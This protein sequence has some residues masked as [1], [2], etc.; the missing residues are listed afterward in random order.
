MLSLW[1]LENTHNGDHEI[2]VCNVEKFRDSQT[3]P[4]TGES[5]TLVPHMSID[6]FIK[7]EL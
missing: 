5:I 2:Q 4:Y 1:S 7:R 3:L 6:Y